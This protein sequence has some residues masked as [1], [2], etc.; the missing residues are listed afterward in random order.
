MLALSNLDMFDDLADDD[1]LPDEISDDP[2]ALNGK[3]KA[4]QADGLGND[5]E[6]EAEALEQ[7]SNTTPEISDGDFID[8]ADPP[9][10]YGRFA[11]VSLDALQN[12]AER[13][14]ARPSAG[15][16]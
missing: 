7:T 14:L 2:F 1:S 16:L 10:A 11:H 9:P 15:A 8:P 4:A 5:D 13:V 3:L 12:R 6:T